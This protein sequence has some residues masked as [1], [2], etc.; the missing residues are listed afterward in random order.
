[1]RALFACVLLD[2]NR[3]VLDSKALLQHLCN[4][5]SDVFRFSILSQLHVSRS[6]YFVTRHRPDMEVVS[7][8]H[9]RNLRDSCANLG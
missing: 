5:K 3:G 2:L 9:P 6:A 4:G 7:A 8:G 1:M